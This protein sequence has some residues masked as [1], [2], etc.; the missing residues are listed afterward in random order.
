MAVFSFDEFADTLNNLN[1]RFI[2][3]DNASCKANY[4]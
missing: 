2:C 3:S 4:L 1:F